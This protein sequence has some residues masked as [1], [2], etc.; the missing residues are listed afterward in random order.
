MEKKLLENNFPLMVTTNEGSQDVFVNFMRGNLQLRENK[1]NA[2][3]YATTAA[4]LP[5]LD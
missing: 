5:P 2:P 1:N 4:K 3:S